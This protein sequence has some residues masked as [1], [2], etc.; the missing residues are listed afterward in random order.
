MEK[1]I[2][3]IASYVADCYTISKYCFLDFVW[4]LSQ[5]SLTRLDNCFSHCEV[6][7]LYDSVSMVIIGGYFNVRDSESF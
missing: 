6:S 1:L 7:S 5:V 3:G 2:G 4:P